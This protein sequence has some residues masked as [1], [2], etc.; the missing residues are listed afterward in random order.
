MRPELALPSPN[1]QLRL[2]EGGHRSLVAKLAAPKHIHLQ[3]SPL[4]RRYTSASVRI[5]SGSHFS[6]PPV[7]PPAM[8]LSLHVMTQ[9]DVP[10]NAFSLM[11]TDKCH[12]SLSLVN[13]KHMEARSREFRRGAL[14]SIGIDV[15]VRCHA[16][17][18]SCPLL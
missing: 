16:E 1:I 18:T 3:S 12:T 7:R 8:L 14:L 11:E 13:R 15:L 6:Q 10:V 5:T 17:D 9:N 4:G 2:R